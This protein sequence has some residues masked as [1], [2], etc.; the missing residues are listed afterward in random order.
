MAELKEGE[1]LFDIMSEAD[2][3]RICY[4]L[5]NKINL[6]VMKETSK[7]FDAQTFKRLDSN[8]KLMDFL[9][10]HKV[11]EDIAALHSR[12]RAVH[13]MLGFKA[14]KESGEKFDPK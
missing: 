3:V 4:D 8:E 11:F 5:L 1:G 13:Q 10:R 7:V 9:K 2:R 6:V 12:S 14:A